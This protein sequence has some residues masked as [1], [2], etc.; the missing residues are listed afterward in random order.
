MSVDIFFW[1]GGGVI[2]S[3]GWVAREILV[4][5]M[6]DPWRVFS[7]CVC[8]CVCVNGGGIEFSGAQFAGR[9]IGGGKGKMERGFFIHY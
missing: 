7:V 6:L 3:V 5:E 8:M 2:C 4:S 1:R 9:G